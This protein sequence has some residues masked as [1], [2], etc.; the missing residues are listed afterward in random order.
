MEDVSQLCKEAFGSRCVSIGFSTDRG[1]VL[2]ADEW[3]LEPRVMSIVPARRGTEE[4]C[5]RMLLLFDR[6]DFQV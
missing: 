6:K 5:K 3:G 1:S 2:A 4:Q